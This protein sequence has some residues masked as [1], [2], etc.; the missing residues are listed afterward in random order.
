LDRMPL[1]AL[2]LQ[3]MPEEFII[4]ALGL[5]LV[6]YKPPLT[7]LALVAVLSSTAS[8]FIRA[9][10]LP[11]GVHTLIL[12]SISIGLV[13]GVLKVSWRIAVLSVLLAVTL[14]ALG[15]SASIPAMIAATAMPME[16]VI[17]STWLRILFPLPHMAVLAFLAWC[18]WRYKWAIVRLGSDE[19]EQL[20]HLG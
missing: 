10:P 3:S 12:V 18:C 19:D 6:G 17:T 11:F 14:L 7:R 5:L 9:L 16:Q 20:P 13:W 2:F 15:E 1:V 8:Y 4:L